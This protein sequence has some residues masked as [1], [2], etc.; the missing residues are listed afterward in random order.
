[1]ETRTPDAPSLDEAALCTTFTAM[2]QRCARSYLLDDDVDDLVQDVVFDCLMVFRESTAPLVVDELPGLVK[3][4]V[5]RRM[6]KDQRSENRRLIRDTAYTQELDEITHTWMAPDLRIEKREFAAF[7]EKTL[8]SLPPMCR[9]VYTMVREE[10]LCYQVAASRLGISISAVSGHVVE[11]QKRFRKALRKQ[12]IATPDAFIARPRRT[13]APESD[14]VI[15][16]ASSAAR[17]EAVA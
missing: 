8:A 14:V 11:A 3:T 15:N 2:A 17:Q 7:Y 1:M 5:V 16:A 6:N 10:D 9:R 12:G 4:I 13:S